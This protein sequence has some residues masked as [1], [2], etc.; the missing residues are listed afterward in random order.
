MSASNQKKIRKEKAEAYMTER[1]RTEAKERKKLKIYTATFWIVLALCVSIL[2]GA[3]VSNPIKNV[4]YKNTDAMTIGNHTLSAVDVNYFYIDAINNYVKQYQNYIQYILDV[5][6]PLDAQTA[7]KETGKTWADTFVEMA[8]NN[9]KSTYALYDLAVENGHKLTEDEQKEVDTMFKNIDTYAKYYGFKNV[10]D[11]LR[12]VYGN[13]ATI[14]SYRA[15]YEISAM[16]DSY[17]T[18]YADSLEYDADALRAYE[19]DKPYEYNS[20]TYAT[21]YLAAAKFR[22]GGTKN[23]KGEITYSDEEKK[24]AIEAAEKVANELASGEYADIE[25][26]NK[27]IKALKINE[28]IESAKCTENDAVLYTKVNEMFQEW[29]KDGA[30]KEGDLKVI[31]SESGSGDSKVINGYYVIRFGSVNENKFNLKDVRHVLIGFKGGKYNSTTGQTTYSDAEKKAAKVEAEK[32]LSEWEKGAKTEDSFADM[33]AQHSTDPGSKGKGGLY[34]NVAPKQ[35]VEAFDKWCY[36]AERKVGDYG[37]VETEYGYHIMYFVGDSDTT[38]RDFMISN[39]IKAKDLE[40][41]HKNLV[42]TAVLKELNM[43][44]VKTDLVLSTR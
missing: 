32:L 29:L 24:A 18:A 14:E 16:A 23:D 37:L 2:V 9:I 1:Q 25:A 3:I 35:M 30:R 34:E 28:G 42:D 17:Y 38:Y 5:K 20:Y 15:Y 43:K 33:A 40:E 27:A 21:Y 39:A 22:E 11:Y 7:D 41:W 6:K 19:K 36:D 10:N 26:F 13:G 44:H 4:I 8:E 12:N 31:A